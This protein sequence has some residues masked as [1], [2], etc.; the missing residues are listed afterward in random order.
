MKTLQ[1]TANVAADGI[2]HIPIHAP[3]FAD[4]DVNVLVMLSPLQ[5]ESQN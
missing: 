5:F 1:L 4:C 2:L 3:D